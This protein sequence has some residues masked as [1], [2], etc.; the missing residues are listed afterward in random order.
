MAGESLQPY[1]EPHIRHHS[2]DYIRGGKKLGGVG[3]GDASK[4]PVL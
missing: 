4:Q 2:T 1:H 3:I